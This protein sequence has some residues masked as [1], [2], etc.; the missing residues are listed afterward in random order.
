MS[1]AFTTEGRITRN[2]DVVS[3]AVASYARAVI[4]VA[5]TFAGT[6][7]FQLSVDG[8]NFLPVSGSPVDGSTAVSSTTAPGLWAFNVAG[9][10][11]LQVVGSSWNT[12]P[13]RITLRAV[14]AN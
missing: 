9:A 4:Q 8:Q 10:L 11:V 13:A 1:N 3:L 2:A 7:S 12:G 14:P 5:D 6:V